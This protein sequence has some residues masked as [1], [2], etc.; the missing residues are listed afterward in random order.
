MPMENHSFCNSGDPTFQS[1]N[2]DTGLIGGGLTNWD[3]LF[4][5]GWASAGLS[6]KSG[7]TPTPVSRDWWHQAML[8]AG[9]RLWLLLLY[10][11]RNEELWQRPQDVQSLKY[12]VSGV[13]HDQVQSPIWGCERP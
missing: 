9:T 5:A 2:Q 11:G 4:W 7:S 1:K 6:A 3:Q 8:P 13:L 12:L 10:K